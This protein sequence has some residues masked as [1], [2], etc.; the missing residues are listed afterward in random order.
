MKSDPLPSQD[1][2]LGFFAQAPDVDLI[3]HRG[4]NGQWPGETTY[5]FTRAL[6]SGADVIEMDVR[7]TADRPPV[8]VLMHSSNISKVTEGSGK[9]SSLEFE[10]DLKDLNAAHCWSP[11]G[12]R[13]FPFA[14]SK[15]VISVTKL[16]DVLKE[17]K[18][19][20]MNIEIKQKR[21]SIVK[22]F[23]D[24]VE[25]CGVPAENLLIA[26]FYT[27]V[28]KEFRK[29][30]ELRKLP[31]ATSA[32]TWEWVRFYFRSY[33]FGL[34]YRPP[35]EALQIRARLPVIRFWLL[36]QR[37]IRKAHSVGLKVH[38]WTIDNPIDMQR[39][40]INGVDGIITDFPGPLRAILDEP[41][42]EKSLPRVVDSD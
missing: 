4:G 7:G 17:F 40:I 31:I 35:A 28:L 34:H 38:A 6:A 26:S 9:V 1:S 19:R 16:E 27:A 25:K 2:R 37:F 8:L 42:R 33:L 36:S 41:D 29:E 21:P 24:L 20:R 12:G 13:T 3:A 23:L 5:A 32:S 30:C 15:Q 18:D 14:N 22:P 11:D 10:R 39:A